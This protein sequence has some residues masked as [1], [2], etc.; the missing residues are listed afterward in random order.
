ME[1]ENHDQLGIPVVG[2]GCSVSSG[3]SER[4]GRKMKAEQSGMASANSEQ[5]TY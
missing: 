5:S 2:S 1:N 3:F 4:P